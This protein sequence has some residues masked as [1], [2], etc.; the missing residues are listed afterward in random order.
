MRRLAAQGVRIVAL[1]DVD[2]KILDA[3]V[4]SFAKR[5][6]RVKGYVDF[7]EMLDDGGG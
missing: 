5:N 6:E 4:E 3:G 7:R 2:R 1:S